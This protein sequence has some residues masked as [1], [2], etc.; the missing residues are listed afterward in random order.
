VEDSLRNGAAGLQAY[1]AAEDESAERF[2]IAW[3]DFAVEPA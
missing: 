3:H 2:L 1:D